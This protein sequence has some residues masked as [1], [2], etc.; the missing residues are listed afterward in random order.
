MLLKNTILI[1]KKFFYYTDHKWKI[2][3]VKG[4]QEVL[5]SRGLYPVPEVQL[6]SRRI[7]NSADASLTAIENRTRGIRLNLL[8]LH[9]SIK[10]RTDDYELREATTPCSVPNCLPMKRVLRHEDMPKWKSMHTQVCNKKLQL[11]LSPVV[12]FS[13]DLCHS[14]LSHKGLQTNS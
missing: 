4:Q 1:D 14:V 6:L 3:I 8:K 5:V 11:S 13:R 7:P 12:N 2:L 10:C 9:L